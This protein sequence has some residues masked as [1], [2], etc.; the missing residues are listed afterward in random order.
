MGEQL[1]F[2]T[3]LE[4]PTLDQLLTPD[5][6]FESGDVGLILRLGEDHRLDYKSARR[7]P[8]D[9]AKE[10]SAFGNG[11][12]HFGGVVVVG[13]EK[14]LDVTGCK[15]LSEAQ[16]QELEKFGVD[17]AEG[18]RVVT[19]RIAC[20]NKN[21]EDDFLILGRIYYNP[22]RLVTLTNGKAY[23]RISHESKQLGDEA[24]SEIRIAKGERV[25]EQETAR[26]TYPDDFHID[27][28]RKFCDRIRSQDGLK[29]DIS[30][31][32]ILE[33]KMLGMRAADGFAPSNALALL[34]AKQPQREFPGAYIRFLRFEGTEQRSGKNFNVIRD[35][36]FEGTLIDQITDCANFISANL[37]EFTTMVDGVFETR[38][39]YPFDAWYELL[40]NAIAHRS[41]QY[42]NANIFVRLFDDRIEFESPGGFMPQVTPQTIYTMHRPRN[43]HLMFAL[44]E[45]GE[46]KCMNEGTKRVRDEMAEAHL[47]EPQF[48]PTNADNTGVLAVLRNDI[49][50]RQ[51]SLDSEAY[52]VLGEALSLSLTPEERKVVNF[53]IEHKTINVSEALRILKTNIWH[54]AKKCLER[55]ESRGILE[56][57]SEKERD[58]K[59]HYVLAR[60][61]GSSRLR[62][63]LH[64]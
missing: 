5:E 46:V 54:T 28:I 36:T 56:F 63:N 23:Q 17:H 7:A 35:R 51:N 30:N 32:Q 60:S 43:R 4:K 10:L 24:R 48:M 58:P 53:V 38:T 52:K 55:L 20:K 8:R 61:G 44:K 47:P 45:F 13:V 50:N 15:L 33:N 37:R 29:Y 18:G 62:H 12:S 25:F 64:P 39:E 59:A 31:E 1:D 3:Q 26:L 2:F 9:F 42:K 11:P 27:R 41:Y 6:I 21:G 40:V 16:L 57:V 19:K 34:F 49:A 22:E 14:N